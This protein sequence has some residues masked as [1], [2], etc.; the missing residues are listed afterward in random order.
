MRYGKS[1]GGNGRP[2]PR[3][4][5]P[6]ALALAFA[7]VLSLLTSGAVQPV[8]YGEEDADGREL[9]CGIEAHQ[10]G[11]DC[12]TTRRTLICGQE[13]T[14][15]HTHT[16]DCYTTETALICGKEETD[17]HTHTDE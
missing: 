8:A 16:A 7:M 9:F 10:H 15:G 12:Y 2:S 1:N 5:A 11:D 4:R 17:G 14:E 6:I 13:E 3:R